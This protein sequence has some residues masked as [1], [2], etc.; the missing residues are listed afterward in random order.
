MPLP[1]PFTLSIITIVVTVLFGRVF[2]GWAC[3]LGTLNNLVGS[4]RRRR[5][6]GK[7]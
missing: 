3:P 1:R 2:C 7:V 6:V 4:I 5:P